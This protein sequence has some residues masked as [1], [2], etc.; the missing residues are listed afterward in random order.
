MDAIKYACLTVVLVFTI[1]QLLVVYAADNDSDSSS[2][3]YTKYEE[4]VDIPGG[5]FTMGTDARNAKDGEGPT[6]DEKVKP[7]KI[8]KYPV[9]NYAFREFVRAKKYKTDAEKYEWSFVFDDFVPEEIKN[10]IPE[11]IQG[12][13]YWIPV[14]RAYWRQP[15]GKG[16]GIES[17]MHYPAVHISFQDAKAYCQWKGWRLPTEKEW[18]FA[19]R[20][21][22]KGK[23]YPWGDKWQK[24]RLN[25]W[26][27][28]FPKKNTKHDGYHGLA[29]VD[30]YP[31]QNEYGLHDMVGNTWEWTSTRFETAQTS[32]ADDPNS[33][34]VLRGG[35]YIDSKDGKFNHQLRVSTR[36]SNTADAG[37][38]NL[39]FRCAQSVGTKKTGKLPEDTRSKPSKPEVKEIKEGETVKQKRPNP[40]DLRGKKKPTSNKKKEAKSE[41]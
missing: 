3:D 41:L 35:S 40:A 26:Q 19:A 32:P 22:L 30:A 4:M 17:R 8:S 37:S 31:P 23:T 39:G 38:D 13:P 6:H 7:F 11:R 21:G 20:G 1:I 16:S 24:N 29:P 25:L 15:E 28:K 34:Y 36:M 10:E 5:E 14:K 2:R 33:T 12:A 18:E 9:T 27:G